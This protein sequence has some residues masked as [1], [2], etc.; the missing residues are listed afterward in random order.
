MR[1]SIEV[2]A[3]ST[4]TCLWHIQR[5]IMQRYGVD[6]SQRDMAPLKWYIFTGRASL[7]FMRRL[8][9]AKPFMVARKLH[10][11]GSDEEV[12]DRV[13]AY[14]GYDNKNYW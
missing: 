3:T 1:N 5:H 14:I 2:N 9:A 8:L 10:M 13:K 11:G 7:D 12:L 4:D 6:E